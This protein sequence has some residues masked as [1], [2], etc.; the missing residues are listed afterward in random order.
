MEF[1]FHHFPDS[2]FDFSSFKP[3][4]REKKHKISDAILSKNI[5]RSRLLK[6]ARMAVLLGNND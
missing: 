3:A 4:A 5:K 1:H 6:I 2:A